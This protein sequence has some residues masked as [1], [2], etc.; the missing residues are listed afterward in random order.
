MILEIIK[1]NTARILRLKNSRIAREIRTVPITVWSLE[2]K[3]SHSYPIH[4][5]GI[6]TYS[7]DSYKEYSSFSPAKGN[8]LIPIKWV[9]KT[10]IFSRK[11]LRLRLKRNSRIENTAI[12]PNKWGPTNTKKQN[13]YRR[14]STYSRSLKTC[15]KINRFY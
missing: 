1:T 8:Q 6:A 7:K 10:A 15:I 9:N 5:W 11:Y 12:S 4:A 2:R 3:K 13:R 14:T